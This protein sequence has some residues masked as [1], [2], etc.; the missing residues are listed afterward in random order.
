MSTAPSS[1]TDWLT[2]TEEGQLAVDLFRRGNKLVIRAA[3][4][5]VRP[6]EIDI[7]VHND[8]LTIRGE[9]KHEE[10]IHKEDWF[11]RECYWGSFSRSILLPEDVDERGVEATVKHGILEITLPITATNRKIIIRA[12]DEDASSR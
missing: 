5:G 10:T 12:L 4:A 6:D 3:V 1:A 7:S 9:R 2:P 8:M 11:H